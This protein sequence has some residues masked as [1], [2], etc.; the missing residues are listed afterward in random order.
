M[1]EINTKDIAD[2][3]IGESGFYPDSKKWLVRSGERNRSIISTAKS[4]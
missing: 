3:P 4:S 1:R 2:N